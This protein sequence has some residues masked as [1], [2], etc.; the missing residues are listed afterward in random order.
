MKQKSK[1]KKSITRKLSTAQYETIDVSVEIEEE[2]EWGNIT[3]RMEKSENITEV[4]IIDFKNTLVQSLKQ[5]KLG[6]KLASITGS[7]KS[8]SKSNLSTN[9]TTGDFDFLE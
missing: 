2:I 1:I 7:S 3:E 5:M 9:D 6:K 8:R 4:L